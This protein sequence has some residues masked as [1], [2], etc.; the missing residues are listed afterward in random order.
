M[1]MIDNLSVEKKRLQKDVA[2][3]LSKI[4]EEARG[5]EFDI[6]TPDGIRTLLFEELQLPVKTIVP[7]GQPSVSKQ[8]LKMLDSI[9]DEEGRKLYPIAGLIIDY[10]RKQKC[11]TM[12][13]LLNEKAK[14]SSEAPVVNPSSYLEFKTS[15][16]IA[17]TCASSARAGGYLSTV[18]TGTGIATREP[19]YKGKDKWIWDFSDIS[20]N[21]WS[22]SLKLISD[23]LK[24]LVD[25][26]KVLKVEWK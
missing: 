3:V 1:T 26:D 23:R 19:F 15:K 7:S 10:K 4:K 14:E 24:I 12:L 18:L 6:D 25:E 5:Y 2:E 13:D 8:A 22:D 21:K 20:D 17:M 9:Q 16:V 11:I